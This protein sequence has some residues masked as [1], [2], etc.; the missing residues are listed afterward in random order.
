MTP[1]PDAR[2]IP[3]RARVLAAVPRLMGIACVPIMRAEDPAANETGMLLIAV[4][5]PGWRSSVVEGSRSDMK[6]VIA[7]AGAESVRPG[8]AADGTG[9]VRLLS[10]TDKINGLLGV[11]RGD[12]SLGS[13]SDVC[14]AR[15]G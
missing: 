5:C 15:D 2:S 7:G 11:G 4:A 8:A 3:L 6:G 13:K 1:D 14:G 9:A 10:N 12:P